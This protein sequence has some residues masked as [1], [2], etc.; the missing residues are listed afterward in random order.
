[1]D[2][3]R[4]HGMVNYDMI[5]MF[6]AG[7][8]TASKNDVLIAFREGRCKCVIATV[9]F[10]MGINISDVDTVIHWG[11][12]KSE[13]AYWQE[14]GRCARDGRQGVSIMY[15]FPHSLVS[16]ITTS[17]MREICSSNSCIRR[18]MLSFLR[19]DGMEELPRLPIC[20]NEN[21]SGSV[22]CNECPAQCCC[23]N[24]ASMCKC[25]Q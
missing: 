12:A 22:T 10:G 17:G 14:M 9:A 13:L 16:T 24:C 18:A 23:S 1:M 5:K 2:K 6:H 8:D 11:C 3:L 7:M 19:I 21:D 15:A 4:L 20:I 25:Q